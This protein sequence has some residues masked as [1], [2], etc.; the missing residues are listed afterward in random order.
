MAE[1]KALGVKLTVLD[2]KS[3][4]SPKFERLAEL[5]DVLYVRNPYINGGAEFLP[6]VVK[7]AQKFRAA[8]KRVIDANVTDGQIGQGKWVDYQR[9]KK[10]HLSIPNTGNYELGIRNIEFPFILKWNYGMKARDVFLVHDKHQLTRILP[11]HP[12]KEWLIQEFVKAEYEYKVIAVGYKALPVVLRFKLKDLSFKINFKNYDVIPATPYDLGEAQ[13]K[14]SQAGILKK[15]SGSPL[16]S[17]RNDIGKI[18]QLA[19]RASKALGR[20][21]AKLDILEAQGK[22]YIL[23][24]NRFPGLESFEKLTK[25]NVARRFIEYL[26]RPN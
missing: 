13:V 21:L 6:V 26:S 7:L 23:E 10:I 19:Q 15:D 2:A 8:G 14:A 20:E 25:F 18:I 17:G 9:L 22:F 16:R 11:K 1:A 4:R 3:L 12:K 24:V 5:Y